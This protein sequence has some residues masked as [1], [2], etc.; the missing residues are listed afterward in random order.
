MPDLPRA[1][2]SWGRLL[3]RLG[4]R[5]FQRRP[6]GVSWRLG[7]TYVVV[8]ASPARTGGTHVRTRP[9]L[10][11]LALHV[12]TRAQVDELAAGGSGRR[13]LF[14]AEYPYAGGKAHYAAYL[15]NEDGFEVELVALERPPR[16]EP[17]TRPG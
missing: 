4:Y 3:G 8:E 1:E 17:L 16:R 6:P 5:E 12:A 9:G 15:E 11:H 13:P 7:P 14:A 2:R 10:N